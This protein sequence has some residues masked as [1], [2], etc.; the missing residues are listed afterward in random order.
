MCILLCVWVAEL[1]VC[2]LYS[3][4]QGDV[5]KPLQSTEH[6]GFS[7]A[8]QRLCYSSVPLGEC[9][10]SSLMSCRPIHMVEMQWQCK[11]WC[12]QWM[13]LFPVLGSK[14][15]LTRLRVSDWQITGELL[16]MKCL[17][18]QK[19]LLCLFLQLDFAIGSFVF[20]AAGVCRKKLSEDTC[21]KHAGFLD[22]HL[23]Y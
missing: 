8:D 14:A 23:S 2:R 20:S 19:V 21:S 4:S 7:G 3:V 13:T 18:R 16:S 12:L 5:V 15:A 11:L 9:Y 1:H 10:H 17:S 22:C 6:T